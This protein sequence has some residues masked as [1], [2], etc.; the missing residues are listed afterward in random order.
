[1]RDSRRFN[2]LRRAA[3]HTNTTMP[4]CIIYNPTAGRGIAKRLTSCRDDELRATT[5]AGHAE[6]LA[7]QAVRDGF[8]TIIAAGGDGTVHEAANG[9]LRS[10]R[11]DVVFAPWP[12]GSA[13][14]Y[15]FALGLPIDWPLKRIDVM[16]RQVDVGKV[17]AGTRSRY[18]VNGLGLGFNAAVTMESRLIPRLRGMALYGLAFL[19]AIVRHYRFPMLTVT[20]DE[21]QSTSPTLALTINLGTR[22]GGFLITPRAKL[23]DGQFDFVQAGPISRWKALSLLPKLAKGTLPVDHPLIRQGQCRL[24]RIFSN[25][26]LRV[27]VDGEF[28]CQPEDGFREMTVEL[29]PREL[30]VLS[31][32]SE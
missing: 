5:Y 30:T 8:T 25:E 3:N 2:A 9:V 22:E 26:P 27:H 23:D 21:V 12:V 11:K 15:A 20:I 19:K 31:P 29:L 32:Y 4:R 10:Q 1:M 6:E 24:V 17:T 28:F 7:L 13:N 16:S 18:F 14:D